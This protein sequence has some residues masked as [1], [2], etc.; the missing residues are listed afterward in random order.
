MDSGT[1]V[2]M[3]CAEFYLYFAFRV[4][5]HKLAMKSKLRQANLK[6]ELECLNLS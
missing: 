1:L 6:L 2:T 3:P 5:S 4:S